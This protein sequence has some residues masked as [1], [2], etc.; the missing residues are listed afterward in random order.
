MPVTAVDI[1]NEALELIGNQVQIT[2]LNDGSPA[3]NA[4]TVL[5]NP[6]VY[7]VLREI[8]PSFARTRKT[9]STVVPTIP[10]PW[11]YAYAYP[12]DCVRM[13]QLSPAPGYN[14][15]DP[16]PVRVEIDFDPTRGKIILTNQV[17]AVGIYTTNA[18]TEDQ[19]DN[20]FREAVVRRLASPLSMALAGRP[21]FARELLQEAE[22][23]A[24]MAERIDE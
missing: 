22:R 20:A 21:D 10:Q 1:V 16:T 19:W 14:Q 2:A 3:A 8:D 18:A 6:T 17:S 5:Y 7:L 24:Q 23:Y 15:N 4:A 12:T 11:T 13:R 9:L